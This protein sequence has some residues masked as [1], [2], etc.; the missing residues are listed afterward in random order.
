MCTF[1]LKKLPITYRL[2]ETL[3][4]GQSHNRHTN[5]ID[6]LIQSVQLFM[7]RSFKTLITFMFTEVEQLKCIM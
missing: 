3:A 2:C 6:A 7:Q 4:Y 1:S 5:K